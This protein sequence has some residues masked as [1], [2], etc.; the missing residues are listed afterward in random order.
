MLRSFRFRW[1]GRSW[2]AAA[3][4][5]TSIAR[6]VTGGPARETAWSSAA[7][8]VDLLRIT[9]NGC[10]AMPDYA[11]QIN[12]EDRW[13]IAA[14]VRALQLSEHA[15]MADVPEAERPRVGT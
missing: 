10:G 13:A 2:C 3:S 6:P 1:T 15:T 14:Y 11:A 12:V 4:D 7:A 8:S 5:S 9:R